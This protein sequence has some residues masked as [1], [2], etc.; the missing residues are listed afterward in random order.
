MADTRPRRCSRSPAWNRE[1]RRKHVEDQAASGLDVQ[2]YC[3]ANGLNVK[4][5]Y[6][7]RRSF[8]AEGRDVDIVPSE[9][10]PLP[11]P[12]FAE[13]VED[14]PAPPQTVTEVEIVLRCGHRLR[15]GPDFHEEAL[16]R[17]VVLL[18]SLPC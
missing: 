13:V 10:R 2:D 1:E 8:L 4:A 17:L 15:V 3:F 7:W 14:S 16:S 11:L 12:A 18:E 5:F 6:G 9:S